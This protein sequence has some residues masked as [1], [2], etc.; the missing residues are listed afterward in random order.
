MDEDVAVDSYRSKLDDEN[1]KVVKI[2]TFL[3][4]VY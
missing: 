1:P 3:L 4:E 2:Q